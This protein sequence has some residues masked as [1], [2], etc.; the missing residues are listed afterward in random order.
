MLVGI[1]EVKTTNV[2]YEWEHE[3]L[4]CENNNYPASLYMPQ[5]EEI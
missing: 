2:V 5:L 4:N 3:K 1:F